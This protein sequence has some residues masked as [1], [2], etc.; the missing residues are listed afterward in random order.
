MA[1]LLVFFGLALAHAATV[2]GPLDGTICSAPGT[3]SPTEVVIGG[4]AKDSA[5]EIV[6]T[7]CSPDI[8]GSRCGNDPCPHRKPRTFCT[9]SLCGR[10][11]AV[12]CFE[13]HERSLLHKWIQTCKLKSV[14]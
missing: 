3:V 9:F 10:C 8:T 2:P 7:I 13:A 5:Q 12:G 14:F 11:T 4:I 6:K 1:A